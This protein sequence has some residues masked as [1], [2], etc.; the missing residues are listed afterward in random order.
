VKDES[1]DSKGW[2]VFRPQAAEKKVLFDFEDTT[3][4]TN[5]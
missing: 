1:V 2:C 3:I 5:T 4:L